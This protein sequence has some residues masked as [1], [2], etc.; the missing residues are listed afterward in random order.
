MR[1]YGAT[2]STRGPKN[3]VAFQRR[4]SRCY[5]AICEAT[6][7]SSLLVLILADVV[8]IVQLVWSGSRKSRSFGS[9]GDLGMSARGAILVNKDSS[10]AKRVVA[11]QNRTLMLRLSRQP[12]A[13]VGKSEN[14]RATSKLAIKP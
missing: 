13:R 9:F 8:T 7:R 1:I 10:A 11:S 5:S 6:L 4:R 12:C 2:G 3:T 14:C